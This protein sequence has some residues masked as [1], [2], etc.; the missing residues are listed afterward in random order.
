MLVAEAKTRPTKESVK[1]FLDKI[2]DEKRRK[3]CQV[4]VKLMSKVTGAKPEMWGPSIVG[5]GRYLHKYENGRE[6]EWMLT[7][8]SPR[9]NDLTLYIIG[10]TDA[11]PDVL[12]RLG[13]HKTR[14]SCLYIKK[15]A[16]VDVDVL[17]ELVEQSVEKLADKRVDKK[18]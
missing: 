16:D 10:G 7:G 9:K 12:K 14:G 11:F 8:F 17:Q 2:A 6:N 4:I 5:C 13:K 1:E 3:D 18:R 15:L